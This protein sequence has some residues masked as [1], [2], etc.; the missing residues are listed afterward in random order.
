MASMK[1]KLI[2]AASTNDPLRKND[3]FMPLSLP[4]LA[5][6]APGHDYTFIDLL[7]ENDVRYD[8]PADL[9]GISV[10][11]TAEN[12]AYEIADEFRR[13]G[14][15]VVL[16]GPQPSMVPFRAIKH[17]DAVAVGEAEELWPV[18]VRD[19]EDGRLKRF[20][21]CAPEPFDP[22]AQSVFKIDTYPDLK[23]KIS[24]ARHFY[25]RNYVFDTVFAVRGCPVNCDFCSVT[26]M[27]GPRFRMRPVAD[28]VAEIDTFKNYYYLLDDSVFGKPAT[29]DYYR[30]LY[31]AISSLKKRRFWTGQANIDAAA[32]EKGRAVIRKA[33]E[34]GLLYAA[35]G[36][37][38]INPKTLAKS[39]A[40]RKMGAGTGSDVIQRM[41]DNIRFV[42]DQGV[43]VSGWF[44]VGYEDDDIETYYRTWEFCR[45]MRV[46]PVIFPVKALPGTRLHDRLLREGKLDDSKLINFRHPGISDEDIFSAMNCVSAAGFSWME[47][48]KRTS[49]YLPRFM[50][51]IIH[52]TIFALVLQTK[53]R[54]A[55]DVSKDEFYVDR[56]PADKSAAAN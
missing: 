13:R 21:V 11:Y 52:K 43:I 6:C 10:R 17:A 32:D 4:I 22:G 54:G 31:D 14:V 44:V 39:G 47:I 40:L 36:M 19:A 45:D 20:Y 9:V 5:G 49:F 33:A 29:Y 30:D 27:S 35:I 25:K 3:P 46:I 50:D 28:V 24:P 56:S 1:I 51:D 18:I 42:Q 2:L 15:T 41:R 37:E 55:I 34:S 26:E 53:L 8:E 16:G 48:L 23:K 12:R 7:W 38:S